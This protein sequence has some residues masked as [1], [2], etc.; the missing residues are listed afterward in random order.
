[1]WNLTSFYLETVLV[2]VHD[3]CMVTL[4]ITKALK[5]FWTH[6]MVPLVDE[7]QVEARFG[8]FGDRA[9]LDSR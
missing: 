8:P 9:N 6:S 1:M 7:A 3:R 5:L 2:S 4:D